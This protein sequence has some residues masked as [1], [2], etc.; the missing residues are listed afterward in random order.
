MYTYFI[1][2][3]KEYDPSPGKT[4]KYAS[5]LLPKLFNDSQTKVDQERIRY[6]RIYNPR[7]NYT[8]KHET[9]SWVINLCAGM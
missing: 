7:L 8:P 3:K 1:W 9:P 6:C 5:E 4:S 2:W